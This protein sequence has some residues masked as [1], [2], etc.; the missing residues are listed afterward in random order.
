MGIFS[1]MFGVSVEKEDAAAVSRRMRETIVRTKVS[2]ADISIS[3]IDEDDWHDM[4][5]S[6]TR[7]WARLK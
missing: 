1:S 3:R 6:H 2:S 5:N 4:T 7:D